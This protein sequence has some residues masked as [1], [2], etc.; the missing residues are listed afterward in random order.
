MKANI[1]IAR[2]IHDARVDLDMSQKEMAAYRFRNLLRIYLWLDTQYLERRR[3]CIWAFLGKLHKPLHNKPSSG[4]DPQRR[5]GY[6][7]AFAF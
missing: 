1:L 6:F 2:K 4:R 7:P 5:N 3:F